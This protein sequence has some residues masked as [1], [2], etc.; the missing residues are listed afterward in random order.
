[1]E[2]AVTVEQWEELVRRVERLEHLLEK[3]HQK[4]KLYDFAE[5][6]EEETVSEGLPV[7]PELDWN[8]SVPFWA[9]VA[10]TVSRN[11]PSDLRVRR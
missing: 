9:L 8:L 2:R 4:E 10:L 7:Y 6:E 5:E 1:M 3:E 11:A